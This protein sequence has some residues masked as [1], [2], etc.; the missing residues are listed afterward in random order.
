MVQKAVEK[1]V[2]VTIL[3]D[4][5]LFPSLWR[6]KLPKHDF[7]KKKYI[8]IYIVIF[9]LRSTLMGVA[10]RCV[11]LVTAKMAPQRQKIKL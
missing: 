11:I 8:Y 7:K 2:S 1:A 3:W 4:L 6:K 10:I 5:V 9:L